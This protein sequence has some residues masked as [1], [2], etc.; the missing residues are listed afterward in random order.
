MQILMRG[1]AGVAHQRHGIA[2]ICGLSRCCID[3][4]IG[5][6]PGEIQVLPPQTAQKVVNVGRGKRPHC[7]LTDD[8]VLRF[9][10]QFFDD[11]MGTRAKVIAGIGKELAHVQ[12][13]IWRAGF[14]RTDGDI[15]HLPPRHAHR[16]NQPAGVR[17]HKLGYPGKAPRSRGLCALSRHLRCKWA[18]GVSGRILHI[19]NHQSR[20]CRVNNMAGHE[21]PGV[22]GRRVGHRGLHQGVAVYC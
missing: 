17:D 21:C 22:I 6:N 10:R 19:D 7:G 1:G 14:C 12:R 11:L 18:G 9:R 3:T 8:M 15:D 20:P 13:G 2:T 16:I 5:R 4:H